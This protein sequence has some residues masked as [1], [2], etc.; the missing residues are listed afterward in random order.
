MITSNELMQR[1]NHLE[2]YQKVH[3]STLPPIKV[4]SFQKKFS[5]IKQ[6]KKKN[7]NQQVV[8]IDVTWLSAW[9]RVY[10]SIASSFFRQISLS[11]IKRLYI[12]YITSDN[13]QLFSFAYCTLNVCITMGGGW[14]GWWQGG[15]GE[16][17]TVMLPLPQPQPLSMHTETPFFLSFF[18]SLL[19]SSFHS[20]SFS[21]CFV[22]D[23]RASILLLLFLGSS[24]SKRCS[25]NYFQFINIICFSYHYN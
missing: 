8:R 15:W 16:V 10:N 4:F 3:I 7:C 2:W 21:C 18:L 9:G 24:I 5:I 19:L 12:Y 17:A 6:D 14:V 13:T 1:P 20:R 25:N 11:L 22:H 23:Y